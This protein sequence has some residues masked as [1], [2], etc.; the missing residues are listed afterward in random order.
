MRGK[1]HMWRRKV[2]SSE[3]ERGEAQVDGQ[4]LC[5][6]SGRPQRSSAGWSQEVRSRFIYHLIGKRQVLPYGSLSGI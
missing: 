6:E 4:P 5:L 2:R 1:E 3:V